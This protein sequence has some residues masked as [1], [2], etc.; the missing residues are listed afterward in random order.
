LGRLELPVSRLARTQLYTHRPTRKIEIGKRGAQI[1]RSCARFVRHRSR[2]GERVIFNGVP[3]G[4]SILRQRR[5]RTTGLRGF[6]RLRAESRTQ[7]IHV[8]FTVAASKSSAVR[9]SID[10]SRHDGRIRV[11]SPLPPPPVPQILPLTRAR[12][13]P[14]GIVATQASGVFAH[15]SRRRALRVAYSFQRGRS[16]AVVVAVPPPREQ[17]SSRLRAA[18]TPRSPKQIANVCLNSLHARRREFIA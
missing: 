5:I 11:A 9:L 18:H 3:A 14:S 16:V 1:Y 17:Q 6:T 12:S 8:G 15:Y 2:M 10:L 7:E 4:G 13:S